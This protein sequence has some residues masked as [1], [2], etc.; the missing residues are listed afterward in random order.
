MP[1]CCVCQG[2]YDTT[3]Y[4]HPATGDMVDA[5]RC[6]RCDTD[7]AMGDAIRRN[8]LGDPDAASRCLLIALGFCLV[9]AVLGLIFVLWFHGQLRLLVLILVVVE[10]LFSA[11]VGIGCYV[12]RFR[13][14]EYKL[15]RTVATQWRPSLI[16]LILFVPI[17][18][19]LI[20]VLFGTIPGWVEPLITKRLW[21]L[22]PAKSTEELAHIVVTFDTQIP[23]S[24]V[25]AL[26]IYAFVFPAV[27]FSA[28]LFAVK[29]YTGYLD[30]KL[31]LPIFLDVP[32]MRDLAIKEHLGKL[33][34]DGK[35]KNIECR[36]IERTKRGGLAMNVSW[37]AGETTTRDASGVEKKTPIIRKA[38]IE[39]D[40]WARLLKVEEKED[41]AY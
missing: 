22:L 10:V 3:P 34:S 30:N 18:A 37:Q 36:G 35:A 16:Q 2:Y 4:P 33:E 8:V 14:R 5:Y 1:T 13:I 12:W 41:K 21:S 39:C 27:T 40:Q 15:L 23:W 29:R 32:R 7:N 17:I 6:S 20:A 38:K 28:T 31:P 24:E 19:L 26:W 11:L 25:V 9:G